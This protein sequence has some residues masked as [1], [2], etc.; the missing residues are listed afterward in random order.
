MAANPQNA[1]LQTQAQSAATG[2]VLVGYGTTAQRPGNPGSGFLYYD[3][4]VGA[5]FVWTGTTWVR[6]SPPVSPTSIPVGYGTTAQRPGS[7]SNGFLYYDTTLGTEVVWNGSSWSLVAPQGTPPSLFYFYPVGSY[8]AVVQTTALAA[9]WTQF[10]LGPLLAG[11]GITNPKAAILLLE[12][13][14]GP[15][16]FGGFFQYKWAL[17]VSNS[18]LISPTSNTVPKI[19]ADQTR[20]QDRAQFWGSFMATIPFSGTSTIMYYNIQG[21]VVGESPFANIYAAGF[22][23]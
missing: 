6:V 16:G 22:I 2:Q 21:N 1:A 5:E 18:G 15:S 3:T 10:D 8:P 4:T 17:R 20:D 23:Y 14:F 19:V 12:A 11:A 9:N 13:G 7:P